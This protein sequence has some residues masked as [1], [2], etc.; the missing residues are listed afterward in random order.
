LIA[1][2]IP[3]AYD[4]VGRKVFRPD[5]RRNGIRPTR[6]IGR[7]LSQPLTVQCAT[8]A[9]VRKFLS[10]CRA[11]SDKELFG[12]EEYWQPPEDFEKSRKGDCEDFSLWTWR[13]FLAMGYDARLVL[14][15]HGRYGIGHAWVDFQRDGKCYL[16]EPQLRV[17][18]EKFP[19]LSTL[20]Y[21]PRFS[22]AW[23]GERL[24]FYSHDKDHGLP[25]FGV[26]LGLIPEWLFLWGRFAF[27]VGCWLP[28]SFFQRLFREIRK[29]SQRDT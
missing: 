24:T 10:S 12:K 1:E 3:E 22:V 16:V 6:P 8:I 11:V 20:R 14:G 13:Q 29:Q 26:L 17:I 28:L 25:N 19:R 18:G 2:T 15:R 4:A 5:L 7:Y 21:Q 23:D 27:R 9:D